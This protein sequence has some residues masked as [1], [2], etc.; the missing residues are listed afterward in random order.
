MHPSLWSALSCALVLAATACRP[1]SPPPVAVAQ[2]QAQA[3]QAAPTP[4]WRVSDWRLPA[5]GAAA[6][7]T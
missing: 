7:P 6:Q 4:Q 3:A 5:A 2:D 1:A